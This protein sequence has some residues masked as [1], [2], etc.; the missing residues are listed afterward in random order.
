M[1]VGPASCWGFLE[2]PRGG[3]E[4]SH[5]LLREAAL[6]LWPASPTWALVSLSLGDQGSSR[7]GREGA[8]RAGATVPTP[9][10]SL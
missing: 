9:A 7:A 6:G 1:G 5:P 8:G 10:G 4:A 3:R 2:G